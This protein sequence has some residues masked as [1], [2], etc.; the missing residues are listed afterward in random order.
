MREALGSALDARD[1]IE[2]RRILDLFAG[3]GAVAFELL[4]RGA[5]HAVL[6]DSDRR[7]I[8]ALKRSASDLGLQD[9]VE[10]RGG[11]GFTRVP[12]GPFGLV[13]LDPPY[14]EIP[15]IGEVLGA[16]ALTEDA[17]VLI[18]H[19]TREPPPPP[20]P[21]TGLACVATYKYGD[22]SLTLLKREHT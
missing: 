18:E 13:F 17:A 16:L 21:E 2:G 6:V 3:T 12:P 7:S 10:I 20:D 9:R 14:A 1:L 15:R 11:D 4:S 22:T 8:K 5:A 19:L